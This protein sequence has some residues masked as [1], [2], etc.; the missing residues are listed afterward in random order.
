MHSSLSASLRLCMA[1]S[2]GWGGWDR[3]QGEGE[4]GSPPLS[5]YQLPGQPIQNDFVLSLNVR[6]LTAYGKTDEIRGILENHKNLIALCVQEVWSLDHIP[7]MPG[8]QKLYYK[9]RKTN[10]AG[11]VG[12]YISDKY[13]YSI[14]DSPFI[15]NT[16]ES[17]CVKISVSPHKNIKL[18]NVYIRPNQKLDD[19]LPMMSTLPVSGRNVMIVGDFNINLLNSKN[20][21]LI[22]KFNE[23]GLS[24]IVDKPTR[25]VH[26]KVGVSK[27]LVDHVYTNIRG[28][29]NFILTTCKTISDHFALACT[30]KVNW[31]SRKKEQ[32]S[33]G[34]SP[35]QDDK[36]LN[37][38]KQYLSAVDWSGVLEDN[39]K[40]CF[41]KFNNIIKEAMTLC[42]PPT[43]KNKRTQPI[44]PWMSRGL[45]VSR[46]VKD[47]LHYKAVRSNDNEKWLIYQRYRRLYTKL[48]RKAKILY[49]GDEFKQAKNDVRET[50]R[51]SNEVMGRQSKKGSNEVGPL[52][53]CNS[54]LETAESF[55][56]FFSNIA[57]DL[58]SKIPKTDA[59]FKDYLPKIDEDVEELDLARGV[60]ELSLNILILK[61]KSKRSFSHDYMSNYALKVVREPLLKPL[62]HIISVSLKLGHVPK[63]WKKAKLIP[64]YKCKGEKDEATNYRGISI[65]PTFSKLI[66]RIVA[67][68]VY[69]HFSDNNLFYINQYGFRRG[70][71]CQDLLIKFMDRVSKAKAEN[72]HFLSIYIDFAKAF[73]TLDTKILL[74]KLRHYKLPVRWFASYLS[75]RYQYTQ[76]GTE[77]SKLKRITCGVPQGSVLDPILFLIAVNCLPNSSS[78]FSLLFAD[79]TTL[80]LEN[81]DINILFYEANI[82]LKQFE[83]WCYCNYLSLAPSKTRFMIFSKIKNVP[84]LYLMNEQIIRV[85]EQ[86]QE[87]SFKLVGVKIDDQLNWHHHVEHIRQK[88]NTALGML[89]RSKRVLPPAIK[90]MI[91][92]SLI[93]SHLSYCQV[94]WCNAKKKVLDPLI[95]AQKRALRIVNNE[96]WLKH[97]DPLFASMDCLK[98]TDQFKVSCGKLVVKYWYNSL[99]PGLVDC[100]TEKTQIRSTRLSDNNRILVQ[101]NTKDP[102]VQRL[103]KYSIAEVW[104]KHVPTS[105]KEF[106]EASFNAAYKSHFI[107]QYTDF[108]C[109]VPNCY[110][111]ESRF[112]R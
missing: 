60:D 79:D 36:S 19:L 12:I 63:A 64:I 7:V 76:I 44:Q 21:S 55:N 81:K 45:L 52:K 54:Q 39:T 22:E 73:D 40:K 53:N 29:E 4:D 26:T 70:M 86:G 78:F 37:Y 16:L 75:G 41:K 17:I 62:S 90:K 20:H 58:A 46:R 50:W 57:T 69:K 105:I 59:S 92:N 88:V 99:P 5:K 66:E 3:D 87:T 11:G 33:G 42:C 18:T 108:N 28:S 1:F 61:M 15:E 48:V 8:F 91:Y 102:C 85:H 23:L 96:H 80:T 95:K 34:L 109:M 14:I 101:Q 83:K 77:R 31:R 110:S 47:K 98:L 24:C 67:N 89:R 10:K 103:P 13:K 71:G 82:Y 112:I 107:Q 43:A 49:Y 68:R 30:V 72:K 100:F 65:L 2:G 84:K 74:A 9:C 111:C 38:L 32:N 51:L 56:D 94:I 25:V 27:T 104:N 93:Q 35:L 6:S 97:C 106:P